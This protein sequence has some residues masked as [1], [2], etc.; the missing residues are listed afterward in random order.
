MV[1][2]GRDG[3][4]EHKGGVGIISKGPVPETKQPCRNHDGDENYP[5]SDSLPLWLMADPTQRAWERQSGERLLGI[6][7]FASNA[8]PHLARQS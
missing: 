3:A 1:Q 5:L 4:K 8:V 7:G 2:G 6:R